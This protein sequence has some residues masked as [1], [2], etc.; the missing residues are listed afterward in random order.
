MGDE[1]TRVDRFDARLLLDSLPAL[2]ADC[3]TAGGGAVAEAE[4][5]DSAALE[6]L[7]HHERWRS[8]PDDHESG[9]DSDSNSSVGACRWLLF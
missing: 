9:D 1:S 6:A 5:M 4:D 3:S 2:A 8:L 7:L